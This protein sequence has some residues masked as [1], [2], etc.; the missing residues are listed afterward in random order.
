M[1]QAT[2]D[3][4]T[5]HEPVSNLFP[6]LASPADAKR[7]KLSDEQVRFFHEN[8]YVA[9]VQVLDN[10][11][12]EALR[13]ELAGLFDPKCPGHELFYEYHSNESTDPSRVLFHAFGTRA[14]RRAFTICSGI[15]RSRCRRRNCSAERFGS[16][17][18]SCSASRRNTAAWWRGIRT[19][20]IGRARGRWRI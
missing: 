15:P 7:Y 16:G 4:S 20:R 2:V 13:E 18:T 3:L 17:T 1:A 6:R 12:V 5:R 10:A 14:L 8:G 19:I 9:G 11:Q